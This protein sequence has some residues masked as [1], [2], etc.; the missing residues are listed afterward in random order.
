MSPLD[1]SAIKRMILRELDEMGIDTAQQGR[2]FDNN[3]AEAESGMIRADLFSIGKQAYELH[4][5]I[6]TYDDLPEWVQSKIVE[7]NTKM[8]DVHD[9]LMY[10]YRRFNAPESRPMDPNMISERKGK[11]VKV[12]SSFEKDRHA[13][14]ALIKAIEKGESYDKL[15]KLT[16]WSDNPEA[17]ISAAMIVIKGNTLKKK[18][19]GKK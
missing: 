15:L 3:G 16:S 14:S 4:D 10:E 11:S 8:Q 6:G 1:R 7:I 17:V 5:V 12:K 2:V 9:Y 18:N 19:N 13:T